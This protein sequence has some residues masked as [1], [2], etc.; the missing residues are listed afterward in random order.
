MGSSALNFAISV[1]NDPVND[2]WHV[3]NA[4][5]NQFPT[6]GFPDYPKYSIWSDGYY[7]T[8]NQ[9]GDNLFVIE[10][11]KVL[12]GD[13]TASIQA[14]DTPS[15]TTAG[16]ASAQVFDIVDDEMYVES[17]LLKRSKMESIS[18]S[19]VELILSTSKNFT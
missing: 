7:V 13:S 16:F 12:T 10:R 2:G 11:D 6:S 4:A 9:G 3:Y 19:I 8:T 14:F 15:Q 17:E 5:S 18:F 1:S